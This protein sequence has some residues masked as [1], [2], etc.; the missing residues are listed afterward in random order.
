M[1]KRQCAHLDRFHRMYALTGA[2]QG[3]RIVG[4]VTPLN[5]GRENLTTPPP[6]ILRS[7]FLIAQI[8]PF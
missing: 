5:F 7:F 4:V 6:L 8:G 3:W 1:T 2:K